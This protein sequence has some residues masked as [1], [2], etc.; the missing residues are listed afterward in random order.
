MGIASIYWDCDDQLLRL[1]VNTEVTRSAVEAGC[2]TVMLDAR[3][4]GHLPEECLQ[5][6]PRPLSTV[7]LHKGPGESIEIRG[8]DEE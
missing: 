8:H 7:P 3:E 6:D 4:R 1:L 2:S 5:R